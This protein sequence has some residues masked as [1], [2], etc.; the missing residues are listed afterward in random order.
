MSVPGAW[1]GQD[2]P[3]CARFSP[4]WILAAGPC[5]HCMLKCSHWPSMTSETLL[6]SITC[7]LSAPALAP[8]LPH[9]LGLRGGSFMTVKFYFQTVLEGLLLGTVSV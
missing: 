4:C 6:V 1:V 8:A 7:W 5:G 9:L 2:G 3:G